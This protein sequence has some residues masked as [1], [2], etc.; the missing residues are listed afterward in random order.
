MVLIKLLVICV[1]ELVSYSSNIFEKITEKIYKQN[2][3][4]DTTH[5]TLSSS[6]GNV[7]SNTLLQYST[8]NKSIKV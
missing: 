6:D 8:Q 5:L 2:I 7:Y 1:D 3:C 4:A